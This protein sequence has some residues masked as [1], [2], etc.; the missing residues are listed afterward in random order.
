M[1][2]KIALAAALVLP[3]VGCS[4]LQSASYEVCYSHPQYGEVCVKLNGKDYVQ[5]DALPPPLKAAVTD[6]V[7]ALKKESPS[8]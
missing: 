4:L 5:K 7:E 2:K 3:L 8:K 6:H 1:L